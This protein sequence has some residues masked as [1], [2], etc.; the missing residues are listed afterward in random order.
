MNVNYKPGISRE[1]QRTVSSIRVCLI[2]LLVAF[3][4][5]TAGR[6]VHASGMNDNEYAIKAAALYKFISFVDWSPQALPESSPT[7]TVGVLGKDPFGSALDVINGKTARGKRVVVKRLSSLQDLEN[8]QILFVSASEAGH[9]KQ[10]TDAARGAGILTVSETKGFARSGGV[11][12]FTTENNRLGMEINTDAAE[13]SRLKISSQLL[14][15]KVTH[16]IRG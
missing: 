16:I 10:I 5:T 1:A 6:T 8:V 11:I 3:L 12:N 9:W 7:V 15:L 2:A 4:F 13:H 14:G